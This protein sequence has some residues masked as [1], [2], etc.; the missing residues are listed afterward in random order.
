MRLRTYLLG[1]KLVFDAFS[2]ASAKVRGDYADQLANAQLLPGLMGFTV[3]VLGHS[4]G[5]PLNLD[6]EGLGA[7]SDIVEYDLSAADA[8]A[9]ERHLH[10]LLVH[11]Y[12]LSLTFLPG[13]FKAWFMACRSKQTTKA[14]NAWTARYFSPMLIDAALD[15]VAAWSD[16]QADAGNGG[17]DDREMTV[18]V[19]KKARQVVASYEMDETT[20]S[21]TLQVPE[22]Y[23][24]DKVAC[25]GT[26]R[27][28]VSEEKWTIW[29]RITE[30]VIAFSNGSL[31]DGLT[32][33]RRNVSS[34]LK[35]QTECAICYCFISEDKKIP[36]TRCST[37]KHLFHKLCLYKW[38]S[39]SSQ[40]TCP[41]CRNL[42][43]L[44]YGAKTRRTEPVHP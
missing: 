5:Q 36:E 13:V 19:R 25:L 11:V 10:R 42:I 9:D 1:W 44:H 15:S 23:P 22:N 2:T 30:G 18:S 6:R 34:T 29:M 31:V 16:E 43:G 27:M 33:F 35:G 24:I 12:F 7:P 20:M 3:D 26:N 39:T 28:L 38:L 14:L 8:E 37:C 17:D 41:L 21:I 32:A 4:V 40:N